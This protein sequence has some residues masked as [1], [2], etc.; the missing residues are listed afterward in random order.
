MGP[1]EHLRVEG[2]PLTRLLVPMHASDHRAP[3]KE[4]TVRHPSI[5]IVVFH[6]P[7][8]N[9]EQRLVARRGWQAYQALHDRQ[10]GGKL[11]TRIVV[12][13]VSKGSR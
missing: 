13:V 6:S 9:P 4:H 2:T 12:P 7:D 10:E 5:S 1:L 8:N 3:R 11:S